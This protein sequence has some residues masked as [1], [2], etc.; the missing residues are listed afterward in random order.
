MS[1]THTW[2]VLGHG[3][4]IKQAVIRQQLRNHGKDSIHHLST[5]HAAGPWCLDPAT[6]HLMMS[7]ITWPSSSSDTEGFR[8]ALT[9]SWKLLQLVFVHWRTY[10][11]FS[12]TKLK[13]YNY[14][15][16]L[17]FSHLADAFIQSDLHIRKS[18]YNY[19]FKLYKYT[20]KKM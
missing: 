6:A 10:N 3:Q 18:N 16:L 5:A 1:E 9:S 7:H 11:V 4:Q 8:R 17:L 2:V 20:F 19:K 15:Y 14:K 13:K 12:L